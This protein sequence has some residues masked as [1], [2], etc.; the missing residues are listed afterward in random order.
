MSV[1]RRLGLGVVS[2]LAHHFLLLFALWSLPVWMD[3]PLAI[4]FLLLYLL[5]NILPVYERPVP[6]RL[7]APWGGRELLLTAAWVCPLDIAIAVLAGIYL[8]PNSVSVALFVTD[9]VVMVLGLSVLALNGTLR[10]LCASRQVVW[11]KRLLLIFLWWLPIA[12]LEYLVEGEKEALSR[13]RQENSLCSTRYPILLVHGVF[14]RD[15]RF[16]NYWGRIP[17]E[18]KP[19]ARS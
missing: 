17:G 3:I 5:I 4:A 14:F 9:C 18:L 12:N 16:F 11:V 6:A 15:T 2:L 1:L 10:I 19:T 7:Q 13:V 8:L